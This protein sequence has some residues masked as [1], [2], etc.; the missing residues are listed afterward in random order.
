MPVNLAKPFGLLVSKSLVPAVKGETTMKATF[1][2]H[3][4]HLSLFGYF[5]AVAF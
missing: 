1:T 2:V 4:W 5:S 3:R